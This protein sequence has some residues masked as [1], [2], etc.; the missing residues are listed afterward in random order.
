MNKIYYLKNF[1][2]VAVGTGSTI[3]Y[4]FSVITYPAYKKHAFNIYLG[5]NTILFPF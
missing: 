5:L 2:L 1:L 3:Y 4:N